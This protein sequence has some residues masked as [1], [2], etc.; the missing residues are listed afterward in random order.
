LGERAAKDS[1][2]NTLTSASKVRPL[3]LH[4]ISA[5]IEQQLKIAS[6]A[7]RAAIGER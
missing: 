4:K 3:L 5:D 6:R 2:R 7:R 1:A